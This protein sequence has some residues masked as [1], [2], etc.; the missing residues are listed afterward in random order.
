MDFAGDQRFG[1]DYRSAIAAPPYD[2]IVG[3]F[4]AG[5]KTMKM[6]AAALNKHPLA[7]CH[8][9]EGAK[10]RLAASFVCARRHS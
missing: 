6:R 4:S 7:R 9:S 2:R 1:R 3:T 8:T 10:T 5:I